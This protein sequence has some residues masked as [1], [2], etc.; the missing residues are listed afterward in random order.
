MATLEVKLFPHVNVSADGMSITIDCELMDGT[1]HQLVL[2][3]QQIDWINQALLSAAQGA[4]LRQV[5]NGT[6]SPVN[7]LNAP[8]LATGLRVLPDTANKTALIQ[9]TGRSQPNE[10][11]GSGSVL[12]GEDLLRG[13]STRLQEVLQ[14]F[15]PKH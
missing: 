11:L 1:V 5:Q 4:Y 6:L 3:Y 14:Q 15:G 10:P 9:M 12:V 7:P 13:L 8:M 2:P